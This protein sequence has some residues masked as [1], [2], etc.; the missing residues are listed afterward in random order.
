MA[1]LKWLTKIAKS[2][3]IAMK[4]GTQGFLASLITNSSSTFKNSKSHTQCGGP[5]CK[6]KKVIAKVSLWHNFFRVADYKS[7]L[8][9]LK[10]I[11]RI[12]DGARKCIQL[13]CIMYIII[14]IIDVFILLLFVYKTVYKILR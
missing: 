1:D 3:L 7:D 14:Y 11:W 12:Q 4:F 13:L 8:R 10:S 2:Y 9:F 6:K 5:K